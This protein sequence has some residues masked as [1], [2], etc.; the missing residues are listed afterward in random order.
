[1]F[2]LEKGNI[3]NAL[4]MNRRIEVFLQLLNITLETHSRIVQKC[5]CISP[6]FHAVVLLA[7]SI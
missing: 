1:M 4:N 2:K 3:E 6:I 7:A 5:A